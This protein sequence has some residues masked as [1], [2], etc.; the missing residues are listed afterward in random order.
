MQV[1]P[2]GNPTIE[3]L[4]DRYLVG[5][6]LVATCSSGL[7][8]PKPTISWY[9]NRQLV[10]S[11]SVKDLS[12]RAGSSYHDDDKVKLRRTTVQLR[13]PLDKKLT[14]NKSSS[15]IELSCLQSMDNLGTTSIYPRN[16]TRLVRVTTDEQQV[17]NQKLYGVFGCATSVS[18]TSMIVVYVLIAWNF[19]F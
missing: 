10:N 8:D 13:L 3:G 16:T 6:Y 14:A 17:K 12:Q 5:D 11:K 18:A 9:L 7:G 2:E 15:T 1:I 4:R 19:L